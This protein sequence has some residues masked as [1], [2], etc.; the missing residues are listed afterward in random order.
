MPSV[1]AEI[2]KAL[3]RALPIYNGKGRI[4]DSSFLSR[5]QFPEELI[6]ITTSDGF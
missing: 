5:Y 1:S 6:D 2:A 3:I 4:V